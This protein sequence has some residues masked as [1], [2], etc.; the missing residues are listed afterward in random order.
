MARLPDL[1]HSGLHLPQAAS[2]K[3][4]APGQGRDM[5]ALTAC[6]VTSQ[7]LSLFPLFSHLHY[8]L[9][10][11][12]SVFLY[13]PPSPGLSLCFLLIWY[14]AAIPCPQAP[15]LLLA[16]CRPGGHIGFALVLVG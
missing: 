11:Y 9:D 2:G 4:Q 6:C 10:S 8:P 16:S 5:A 13:H 7:S 15:H 1:T 3:I 12:V 14:V